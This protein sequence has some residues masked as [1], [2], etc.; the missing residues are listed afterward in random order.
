MTLHFTLHINGHGTGQTVSIQR[1][2]PKVK[3]PSPRTRCT[4]EA[5]RLDS[6][7]TERILIRTITHRYGDG[8]WEL[9]RRAINAVCEESD[10]TTTE[11][12]AHRGS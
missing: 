11:Q 4:Y 9:I 6:T 1:T 7:A 2:S 5:T 3:T 12:E 8:T 10:G